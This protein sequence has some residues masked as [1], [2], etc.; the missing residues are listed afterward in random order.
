[1]IYFGDILYKDYPNALNINWEITALCPYHC[2]YCD[3]SK[4]IQKRKLNSF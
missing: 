3:S 4:R 2:K 1:M